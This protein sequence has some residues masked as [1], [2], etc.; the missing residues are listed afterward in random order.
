MPDCLYPTDNQYGI[1]VLSLDMQA[2]QLDLPFV[3][4]G[5][6]KRASEM[7]GTWHFYVDDYRFN[8]LWKNP[9][10]VI[11]S[12]CINAVEPNFSVYQQTP[13]AV[14][15]WQ[16]YRKR[17]IARFWQSKGVRIFVDMNVARDRME[18]NLM[19]IPQGWESFC[20]RGYSDRLYAIEEEHAIAKSISG[21]KQIMFV[22]YGGGKNVHQYCMDKGLVWVNE[23]EELS[24]QK[25][26]PS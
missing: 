12:G 13:Q 3:A 5:T 19:G 24:K 8:A 25:T 11:K 15:L 10:P 4:W 21:K 22:V 9:L 6:Q 16:I 18:D 23:Q 7:R 26:A 1:P 20:T 17:Y 14:S 2:Q